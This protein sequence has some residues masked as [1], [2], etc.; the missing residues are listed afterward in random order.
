MA[1]CWDLIAAV[2]PVAD[3]AQDLVN[4]LTDGCHVRLD[5]RDVGP[6]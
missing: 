6:Q 1:L 5:R 2:A 4:V 3:T